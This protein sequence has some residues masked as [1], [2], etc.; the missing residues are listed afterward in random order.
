MDLLLA[1]ALDKQLEGGPVGWGYARE[2]S[3]PDLSIGL[4]VAIV[5]GTGDSA[6][7]ETFKAVNAFV[8]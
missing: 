3:S 6:K 4:F 7:R 5:I 8:G 2:H 1:Q